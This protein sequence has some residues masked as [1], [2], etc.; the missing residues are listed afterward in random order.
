MLIHVLIHV[1]LHGEGTLAE[2]TGVG[3]EGTV[4]WTDSESLHSR[5]EKEW[6]GTEE[7]GHEPLAQ[8]QLH[9]FSKVRFLHWKMKLIVPNPYRYLEGE[10]RQSMWSPGLGA[11]QVPSTLVNAEQQ[12]SYERGPVPRLRALPG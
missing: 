11:W 4:T 6:Q 1:T 7:R 9:H 2:W 12:H 10:R 5:L 8:T 3:T